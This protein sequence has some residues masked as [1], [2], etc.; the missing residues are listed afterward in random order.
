[1]ALND[2]MR[3]PDAALGPTDLP[4]SG[5]DTP[6]RPRLEP[7]RLLLGRDATLTYGRVP[8]TVQQLRALGVNLRADPLRREPFPDAPSV[9]AGHY[10][11]LAAANTANAA[12]NEAAGRY[13][14][15]APLA[16]KRG[17]AYSEEEFTLLQTYAKASS[18][19][20]RLRGL[21]YVHGWVWMR[22][23]QRLEIADGALVAESTVHISEGASLEITHTAGTRALP[24]LM[25]LGTGS[26][27]VMRDGRLRAHGLVHVART[28]DLHAGAR[29]DVVGA[30]VGTSPAASIRNKGAGL[31]VRYD[32]AV[33]G[34]PG[35][36]LPPGTP[37]VAWVASVEERR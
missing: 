1:V 19:P 29:A 28:V 3:V 15:H 30:V 27:T 35:L 23:G 17:S 6:T 4:G 24:G 21:I 16:H 32:P 37:S 12:L 7:V 20:W 14:N 33:L 22:A 25:I 36:L 8:V 31:V 18:V 34:T 26:L 5:S 10:R 2:P 13:F 9:N 11:R